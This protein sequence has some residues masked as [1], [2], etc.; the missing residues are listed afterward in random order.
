LN[1]PFIHRDLPPDNFMSHIILPEKY[2]KP[3]IAILL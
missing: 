3:E 2:E 1:N